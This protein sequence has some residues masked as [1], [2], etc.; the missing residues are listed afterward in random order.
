MNWF[1][2]YMYSIYSVVWSNSVWGGLEFNR[3]CNVSAW[4]GYK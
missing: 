4:T 2:L 3:D 1:L